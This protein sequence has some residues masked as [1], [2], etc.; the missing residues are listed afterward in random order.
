MTTVTLFVYGTLRRGQANHHLLHGQQFLG[1]AR[2]APRY[3]LYDTGAYTCLVDAETNGR[4]I[5]G[6]LWQ[7]D[8]R[9]LPVL[10]GLEEAPEVFERRPV[11]VEGTDGPV[12]A[13]FYCGP[14][15]GL[16]ERGG[17]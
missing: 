12:V 10:D 17:A 4:A 7:T 11:V 15:D 6:E 3:R 9:L 2:T 8:V 16:D 5:E 1:T 14:V 13:Y